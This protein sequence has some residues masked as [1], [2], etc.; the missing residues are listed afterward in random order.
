MKPIEILINAKDNASKVFDGIKTKVAA[1]AAAVAAY[2]GVNA[3]VGMIKGAADFEAALSAVQAATGAS[4]EEMAQ[5][6]KAAEGLADFGGVEA[7]QALESL[8]KAGL[9][10]SDAIAALKPSADLAK[11]GQIGLGQASEALTQVIFGLGLSFKDSARVADVLAA[12]ANSTKTS[13]A[14]LTQAL[15]YAAPVAKSLGLSLESTVALLGQFAQGG[16]DASRAGTAL[17]SIM[18]QFLDP[19]S[20]FRG[21]L[22]AAGITTNDF[23]KALHQLA[24]AGPAGAKAINAVGLESGPALRAMLNLGMGALDELVA[25]LGNAEGEAARTAAVLR[26]NLNGSISSLGKAWEYLTNTL[27]TPVLPVIKDG[28]DQLAAA[29]RNAVADGT[30]GKFGEAIA[31]AFQSGIKWVREFLGTVDFGQLVANLQEFAGQASEFFKELGEKATNAGVIVKTAYGLMSTGANSVMVAIYGIGSG[32]ATVL[33]V[34]MEGVVKLREAL[35]MVT[36]GELSKSFEL[37]AED[38]RSAVQ[39]FDE[40][41]QAMRDKAT[42]A[43]NAITKASEDARDGIAG[44]TAEVKKTT[45][46]ITEA[47]KATEDLSRSQDLARETTEILQRAI[48]AQAASASSAEKAADG[49]AA[50]IGRL[51]A[52]YDALIKSGNLQEAAKKLQQINRQLQET[53]K[54]AEEAALAVAGA[55]RNLGMKTTEDLNEMAARTAKAYDTLRANGVTSV[56]ALREAFAAMATAAIEAAERQGEAAVRT[57]RAMLDSKAAAAGLKIEVTETGQVIVRSMRDAAAAT[58]GLG[59]SVDRLGKGFQMTREAIEAQQDAMAKLLLNYTMS[60]DY[61]ERQIALLEREAA[62]A[63]KAAE[64]YRKKWN[65]DKEGYSLNTAG[66]RINQGETQQ[67]VDEDVARRYGKDNVDNAD[68]QRAR[69]LSVML[70][71]LAQQGGQIRDPGTAK[72]IADMRR[73]L[74]ELELK[75][76]NTAPAKPEGGSTATS[77]AAPA[78]GSGGGGSRSGSS[79]ISAGPVVTHRVLIEEK[80]QPPQL[81]NTSDQQSAEALIGVLRRSKGTAR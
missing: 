22:A 42:A 23:M 54:S 5:L 37:A 53:P 79:G 25:K 65:M 77:P 35:A 66:E 18:S 52:E 57:T 61:S 13:V 26:N 51:R 69:Q 41:A 7:A 38:A 76:L 43:M 64:A 1:F 45:P 6:R 12:G 50:S 8:G 29:F 67:Q 39:G 17:N 56:A 33:G 75:L 49:S 9:S 31:T 62:A 24:A 59:E 68:A 55:F 71:Y 28:V 21:E 46:A 44:V 20:K 11:A 63:E 74:Q 72:Q 27:G 60:A 16:I 19:A 58:N 10:A 15:S 3:F 81:V 80:G 30:V 47:A 78:G 4:A 2:L 32:F 40:A 70:G 73:E 48:D 34:F 14:G 36:F